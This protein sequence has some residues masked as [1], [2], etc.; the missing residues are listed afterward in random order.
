MGL[1]YS[2]PDPTPAE[3]DNVLHQKV[4]LIQPVGIQLQYLTAMIWERVLATLMGL[5]LY[6]LYIMQKALQCMRIGVCLT[7]KAISVS[8]SKWLTFAG[9]K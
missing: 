1:F 9:M 4:N 8:D 5:G 6:Y 7:H 2:L 3:R